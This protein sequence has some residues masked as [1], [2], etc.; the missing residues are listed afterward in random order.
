MMSVAILHYSC[1]PVIGGV[2]TVIQAHAK[3]FAKHGY[4]V[5]L[6]VGTGKQFDS[7]IPVT[8]IPEMRA[9][10][11]VDKALHAETAQGNI[12]NRFKKLESSLYKKLKH[13]LSR[14]S[15]C[16]AHNVLTMHFNLALTSALAKIINE[17]SREGKQKKFI[18]WAHDATFLDPHYRKERKDIYPWNLLSQPT[19]GVKQVT[20]S[21]LRKRKLAQLFKLKPKDITVVPDGIDPA[22]FLRLSPTASSLI[23]K[24]NL[25]S[26]DF[27]FLYPTRMV[28]RKNIEFAIK[29]IYGINSLGR[30]TCLLITSP[31]DPHNKDSILYYESLKKLAKE[32]GVKDK[33]IFLSEQKAAGRK[34]RIDDRFLRDLYLLSDMLLFPS[35][36][37]GFGIPILESGICHLPVACSRIA[38]LT[39][40]G[41]ENVLYLDLEDSVKKTAG[42]VVGY[43]DG[44]RTLRLHKKVMRDYTWES[45]F[46]NRIMPLIQVNIR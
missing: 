11:L 4:P 28:R 6:I 29:L 17:P 45:I 18:S 23:E 36:A 31:P 41:G 34:I 21:N 44:Y 25:S 1:Y 42:K 27:V 2:E 24:L 32:L 39:E 12:S 15:I 10:H 20:I 38:P 22:G 3:L 37:E 40:V 8:V 13:E 19:G 7:R 14:T 26:Y 9:L 46:T 30:K 43:L 5:K 35:K 33:V 16:I